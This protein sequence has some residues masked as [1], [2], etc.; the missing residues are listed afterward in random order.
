MY[1]KAVLLGAEGRCRIICP[2]RPTLGLLMQIPDSSNNWPLYSTK[3]VKKLVQCIPDCPIV[4]DAEIN[5][6]GRSGTFGRWA[7]GGGG[8]PRTPRRYA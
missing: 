6:A 1:N 3:K 7:W 8:H 4:F 2:V 5:L